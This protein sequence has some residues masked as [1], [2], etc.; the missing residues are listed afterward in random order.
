[1]LSETRHEFVAT[2]VHSSGV[3]TVELRERGVARAT[4]ARA[5]ATARRCRSVDSRP[6][7]FAR[8]ASSS[9]VDPPHL[10]LDM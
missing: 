6:A 7:C 4:A 3:G 10:I 5:S 1:M 8:S 2:L 9:G